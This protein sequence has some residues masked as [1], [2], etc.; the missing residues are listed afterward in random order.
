MLV[1]SEKGKILEQLIEQSIPIIIKKKL[2]KMRDKW[3]FW[4]TH[5]I[6]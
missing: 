4:G 2:N 3:S 1:L 5:K 6:T